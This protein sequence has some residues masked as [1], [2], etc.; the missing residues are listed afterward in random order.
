MNKTIFAVSLIILVSVVA[1]FFIPD[2]AKTISHDIDVIID[3][4]HGLPDGGAVAND[5]TTEADLNLAIAIMLNDLLEQNGLKCVMTRSTCDSIYSEG[6]NIH[7]KKIS[8]I[9]NRVKISKEHPE[10]LLVSIH[11]NTYPSEDVYGAQVFYNKN[12]DFSKSVASEIQNAVNLN[13]QKENSKSI[14]QIPGNVYLFNHVPNDCVL[15]ECGFLTN[16]NDLKKLKDS[17]YQHKFATTVS[18]VLIYK[19]LGE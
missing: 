18:E 17:E 6:N 11:M 4:G 2:V 5:G 3:A 7:S 13:F 15:I 16:K 14:K 10:A 12:S 9:R 8:D 19:L 1:S